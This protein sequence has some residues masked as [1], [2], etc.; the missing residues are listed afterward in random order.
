MTKVAGGTADA[1]SNSGGPA[2]GADNDDSFETVADGEEVPGTK[3]IIRIPA[4]RTEER[5]ESSGSASR[6]RLFDDDSEEED[7]PEVQQQIEAALD[8]AGPLADLELS[9]DEGP[10]SES[11]NPGDGD[12][13][14]DTKEYPDPEDTS[15]R[16][17]DPAGSKPDNGL[18]RPYPGTT[19]SH[20]RKGSK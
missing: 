5:P 19:S 4:K 18:Y 15:E 3:V 17:H 1:G 7:N 16:P 11:E 14:N 10:E 12:G 20:Q 2:E 13:L 6:N 8:A 9:E